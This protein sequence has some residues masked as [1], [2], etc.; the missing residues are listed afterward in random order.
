MPSSQPVILLVS[1]LPHHHLLHTLRENNF[2]VTKTETPQLPAAQRPALIILDIDLPGYN[3]FELCRQ[4]KENPLTAAIPVLLCAQTYQEADRQSQALDSGADGFLTHTI[5]PLVLLSLVKAVLRSPASPPAPEQQA[6]HLLVEHSLQGLVIMQNRQIM[7]ANPAAC[8]IT[9]YTP[10]EVQT[11]GFDAF[12][13]VIHPDDQTRAW[14][15]AQERLAGQPVPPRHEYRIIRR[16]GHTRWI[17]SFTSLIQYG[18]QPALQIAFVDIT[19]RKQAEEAWRKFE[20]VVSATTDGL[21]L[22]DK[23]YVY[24]FVNRTYLTLNNKQYEEIVGHSIQELLGEEI[25]EK[26]IKARFDK[27]LA[28]QTIT[29]QQWFA[30][31][32]GGRRFMNVTY[33]PYLEPDNSISGVVVTLRDLTELK[34]AEEA[35]QESQYMLQLV[36]DH[37]PQSISWKDKKLVYLGCNRRFAADAGLNTPAEII[38]KTDFDLPWREQA[39]YYHAEETAI[40]NSGKPRLNYEEFQTT[41]GEKEICIQISK[42]PLYDAQGQIVGLV[43]MFED[44]TERIR[45]EQALRASETHSRALLEA[46]PDMICRINRQGRY[47]QV[48]APVDFRPHA[49]LQDLTG[50][51]IHETYPPEQA[52]LLLDLAHAAIASHK[53]QHAEIYFEDQGQPV[54]RDIRFAACDEQE[55]LMIVRDIT[56]RKKIEEVLFNTQELLSAFIKYSPALVF[57]VSVEG[58]ILLVNQAWE[59]YFD[60]RYTQVIG[61]LVTEVFPAEIANLFLDSNQQV[62]NSRASVKFEQILTT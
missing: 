21:S 40:I 6:Y 4:L 13:Q 9:G 29:Y 28:G 17:E 48:K 44:I 58:R 32:G 56:Q 43:N 18:G 61:R 35:L 8:A 14:G 16:D 42:V 45:T 41:T 47:L 25:F 11:L 52:E 5:E 57:V 30:F 46:I 7:F 51:T 24:Q 15:R 12:L 10:A 60:L 31:P 50:A 1:P 34:R 19:E 27:A 59:Q 62:I 38:G 3:S 39:E 36:M 23:N 26:A 53:T 37:A 54:Y 33:S 55:A 49:A 20:R 22:V 2:T